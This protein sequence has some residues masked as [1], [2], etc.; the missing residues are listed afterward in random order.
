MF[1]K[2]MAYRDR[3]RFR[4]LPGVIRL[5]RDSSTEGCRNPFSIGISG[6]AACTNVPLSFLLSSFVAK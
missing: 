1:A 2:E 4:T 3:G 5:A 6:V